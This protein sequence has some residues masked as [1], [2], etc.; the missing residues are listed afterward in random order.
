[1]AEGDNVTGMLSP[2]R[3][4]DLTDEKGLL[5][6]KMLGDLGADVIKIERPG[7][8]SSRNIGPYY[9]D[10]TDPEKSLYWF[11]YNANK[12]GITLDIETPQGKEIFKELVKTAD[13]V[14]ESFPP[15][16][17]KEQGLGYDELEKINRDIIVVS[18][19]P[20]GQ[21]GPYR[22]FKYSD[23]TL[24]AMGGYMSSVGDADRPPVRISHH[25]QTYLHGGGQAAQGVLLALYQR[26]MTGEGQYIDV[27]IHD[28]TSRITPERVT[29]FWDFNKRVQHRGGG[30]AILGR[31]WEC[32]D[33]YVY[34]M[35]WGGTAGK[36][37]NGPIVKWME[38]EGVATDFIKE[39]NWEELSLI[40]TAPEVL[41][42]IAEPTRELFMR[43]TKAELLE[44]AL[45]HNAQVYPLNSTAEI[46]SNRQLA[47]RE[48]WVELEHPELGTTITYP[49][50]FA[51]TTE[52]PPQIT[53]RAP[54]IGEHNEEIY[55][56]EMGYSEDKL[57]E[58]K[59]GGII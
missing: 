25:F 21:T 30:K 46:A 32:K 10:E 51:K 12:R 3:V 17:M 57:R 43:H 31:I 22:D 45:V 28:S 49:G 15:G 35:Y 55:Q 13:V 37:W 24:Y 36:R 59:Q 41:M 38:S 5:C 16:Y 6:G 18:I 14:V 56:G 34:A 2:Y 50:P 42:K 54:L 39:F 19:T 4:L 11:S 29:A 48:Y 52:A 58:L 47:S 26:E 27:S 8:D 7:G 53:R 23:I 20:Y 40:H 1:M 9:H 33:G 44:A